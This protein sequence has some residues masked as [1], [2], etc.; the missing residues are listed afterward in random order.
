MVRGGG[1]R[2]RGHGRRDRCFLT[3]LGTKASFHGHAPLCQSSPRT[4]HPETAGIPPCETHT[5]PSLWVLCPP[6]KRIFLGRILLKASGGP[7][8]LTDP[9]RSRVWT[10][11]T[12]HTVN[13]P[14]LLCILSAVISG[15]LVSRF[16]TSRLHSSFHFPIILPMTIRIGTVDQLL[17]FLRV[18]SWPPQGTQNHEAKNEDVLYKLLH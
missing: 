1:R 18:N 9:T 8:A 7:G 15:P 16:S 12:T 3:D 6:S 10:V 13:M 4:L 14:G 11:H 17:M 2:P 5:V